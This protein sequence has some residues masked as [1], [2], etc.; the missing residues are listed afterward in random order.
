MTRMPSAHLGAP[1]A[2]PTPAQA[3]QTAAW[4]ATCQEADGAFGWERRRHVDAW[5][6]TEAAMA[7][8]AFGEDEAADGEGDDNKEDDE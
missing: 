8:V 7:L 3:R 2:V 4:L 1:L 5:N 6:H